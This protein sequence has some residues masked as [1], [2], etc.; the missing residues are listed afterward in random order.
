MRISGDVAED[1]VKEQ[2][3]KTKGQFFLCQ[4]HPHHR[5]WLCLFFCKFG[6]DVQVLHILFLICSKQAMTS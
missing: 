3:I 4:G 6:R 2:G 5:G 1:I